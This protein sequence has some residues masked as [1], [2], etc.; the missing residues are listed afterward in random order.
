MRLDRVIGIE[1]VERVAIT[2]E[3]GTRPVDLLELSW[4]GGQ[5]SGMKVRIKWGGI[6]SVKR[7]LNHLDDMSV[8]IDDGTE[9]V[10][11]SVAHVDVGP[12]LVPEP[13]PVIVILATSAV[14]LAIALF[15]QVPDL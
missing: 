6:V 3:L 7:L 4:C 12:I 8:G 11:N 5:K 15:G 10:D 2:V 9:D 1:R 13:F 14:I